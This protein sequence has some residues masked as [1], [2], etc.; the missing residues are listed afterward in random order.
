ML[1]ECGKSF[2]ARWYQQQALARGFAVADALI[3]IV[4]GA[5]QFDMLNGGN[6]KWGRYPPYRD[7]GYAAAAAATGQHEPNGPRTPSTSPGTSLV[8]RLA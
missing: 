3:P 6:K 2:T 7:L 5:V 1:T 4:P 8:S